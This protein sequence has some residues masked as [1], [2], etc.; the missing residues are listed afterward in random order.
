MDKLEAPR[1][2]QNVVEFTHY[3]KRRELYPNVRNFIVVALLSCT[4]GKKNPKTP[5]NY[6]NRRNL[7]RNVSQYSDFVLINVTKTSSEEISTTKMICS[8]FQVFG[9]LLL[10][11][12]KMGRTDEQNENTPFVFS[13]DDSIL[14]S[15]VP[16]CDDFG[17]MNLASIDDFCKLVDQAIQANDGQQVIMQTS[18]EQRSLTNAVFLLGAY[19]ILKLDKATE[20][21]VETFEPLAHRLASYRDV[22]PGPQTFSLHLCDCWAGLW[23]AKHLA[24]VKMGGEDGFDRD[25]YAELDSPLNADL[26]VVVPGKFIAMRGPR[27][28]PGGARWHDSTAPNG[29]FSHRDFSPAH[30]A[31][32][33]AQ[34]D[35]SAVV[36]LNEPATYNPAPLRAAGI[37][38]AD[39][40][41]DDCTA[42]PTRVVA[43]FMA[44]AE[45]LPGALAVHCKAGLG[46][47]GTL[48]ALY[49]MK[50][51]GFTAR[52]AMGWLRIVRPGSVIGD[53]Q[54][55]LCDKEALMRQCG[56]AFRRAGGGRRAALRA[57][58]GLKEVEEYIAAT[59]RDIRSRLA[60]AQ[61]LASSAAAGGAERLAAHVAAAA[62]GRSGR[63]A[64]LGDRVSVLG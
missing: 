61:E 55:F 39:L 26:H 37:A 24:W 6:T 57:G 51:H 18:D 7:G 47:T 45:D 27:D 53:Q 30:Y 60:A 10:S 33:L 50:H 54:Q 25:E 48:I 43:E 14:T 36:R 52:E 4:D 32:I 15:Y 2:L 62:E 19:M 41:F 13:I 22:S 46:R 23:R 9:S 40:F 31:E 21:V 11:I 12:E 20:H 56:A 58:S 44:L 63:R 42:P 28:F 34:F 8:H 38:V 1:P 16:F 29:S 35:V 49:M 5:T 17:P 64:S 59:A 3:F